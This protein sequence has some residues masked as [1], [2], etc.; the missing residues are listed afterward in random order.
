MTEIPSLKARLSKYTTKP[1]EASYPE[2]MLFYSQPGSGKTYL[3]ATVS[4]LPTVKSVLIID[5]EGSTTGTLATFDDNKIDIVDIRK[6]V[7]QINAENPGTVTYIAFLDQ[8]LS[9]LFT[10]GSEY[11]AVVLDTLDVAQDWKIKER[12]KVNGTKGDAAFAT[13]REVADWTEWVGRGFKALNA[14]SIAVMHDRE[15]KSDSG[16]LVKRLRLGGSSKDTFAGIPDVVAYLTRR[17]YKVDGEDREV[18]IAEFASQDGKA[19]KNRFGFD[20]TMIDPSIKKMWQH[21]DNRKEKK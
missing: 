9:D 21:I 3:A 6:T 17:V 16:A 7:D 2:F 4:E 1:S 11:D 5:T 8:I 18:T 15:E 13:W 12:Q 20:S 10:N 19:T 14:I